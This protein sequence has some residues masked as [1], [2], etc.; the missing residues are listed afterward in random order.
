MKKKIKMIKW[1]IG[2][3]TLAYITISLI[4]KVL[5]LTHLSNIDWDMY[6]YSSISIF[7]ILIGSLLFL[8]LAFLERVIHKTSLKSPEQLIVV[9]LGIS[10]LIYASILGFLKLKSIGVI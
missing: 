1:I 6:S 4:A 5:S 2:F 9:V 10:G 3:I 8:S 7:L